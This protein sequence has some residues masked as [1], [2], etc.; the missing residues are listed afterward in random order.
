MNSFEV[1]VAMP[2]ATVTIDRWIYSYVVHQKKMITT[3]L[4]KTTCVMSPFYISSII[5]NTFYQGGCYYIYF[6]GEVT[7]SERSK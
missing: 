2:L 1:K 6:I 7:G 4:S 3:T 5:S